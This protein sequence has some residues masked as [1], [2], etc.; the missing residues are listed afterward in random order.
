MPTASAR[1]SAPTHRRR[2][3]DGGGTC[4]GVWA[5]AH[6]LDSKKHAQKTA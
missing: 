3:R 1:S 4:P 6:K 2:G 5:K